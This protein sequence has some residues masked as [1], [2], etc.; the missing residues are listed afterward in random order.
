LRIDRFLAVVGP[1]QWQV[2]VV[3]AGSSRTF[4]PAIA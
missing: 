2:G 1:W 3:R 4:V